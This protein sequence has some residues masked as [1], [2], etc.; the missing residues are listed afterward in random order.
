MADVLVLIMVRDDQ[1]ERIEVVQSSY[2]HEWSEDQL[3]RSMNLT[4]DDLFA[5]VDH[6]LSRGADSLSVIYDSELGYP[7]YVSIDFSEQAVDDEI[8]F[9]AKLE[10]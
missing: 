4:I 10:N 7:E 5:L 1:V 6:A 8:R 9:Q 2:Q 3:W